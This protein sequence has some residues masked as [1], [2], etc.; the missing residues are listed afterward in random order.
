MVTTLAMVWV[1]RV[2]RARVTRARA[3]SRPAGSDEVAGVRIAAPI[4]VAE[5]LDASQSLALLIATPRCRQ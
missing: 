3:T 4:S 5:A 2:T 1:M